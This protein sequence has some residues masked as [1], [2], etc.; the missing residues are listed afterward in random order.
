MVKDTLRLSADLWPETRV[1]VLDE[2]IV[3][4]DIVE[5]LR[6]YLTTT[7]GGGG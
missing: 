5:R 6:R 3:F 7:K 1:R 2:C 4:E